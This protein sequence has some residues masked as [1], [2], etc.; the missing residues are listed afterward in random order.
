MTAVVTTFYVPWKWT[1]HKALFLSCPPEPLSPSNL[2]LRGRS[3]DQ[4]TVV[5]TEPPSSPLN[6]FSGFTISIRDLPGSKKEYASPSTLE[7]T[8]SNLSPGTP[9]TI[10]VRTVSS[11][12]HSQPTS[13]T[14]YTSK[15]QRFPL[16][17]LLCHLKGS[18]HLKAYY[19]ME[20]WYEASG[21]FPL[22]MFV[23]GMPVFQ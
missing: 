13:A 22:S 4:L 8:F 12:Q 14:F 7:A 6:E 15:S 21:S 3:R 17:L 11:D 20:T 16:L 10:E 23:H 1:L 18:G 5:W 2:S 19:A 9:Y